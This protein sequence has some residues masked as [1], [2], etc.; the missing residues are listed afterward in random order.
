V[1]DGL[2]PKGIARVMEASPL[3]ATVTI[4]FNGSIRSLIVVS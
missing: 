1:C 2:L 4:S 3:L